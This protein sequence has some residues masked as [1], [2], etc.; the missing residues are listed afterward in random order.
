M[1]AAHRRP[2]LPGPLIG[3]VIDVGGIPVEVSSLRVRRLTSPEYE[4]LMGLPDNWTL[5]PVRAL[6]SGKIVMASD[7]AR[8]RQ[9]DNAVVVSAAW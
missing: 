7:S 9:C 1:R 2:G 3:G 6:T 5:V 8:Y 4:R